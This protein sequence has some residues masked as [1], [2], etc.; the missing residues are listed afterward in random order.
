MKSLSVALATYNGEP[1]LQEELATI[2]AQTVLPTE[3][4]VADDGSTD[5]TLAIVRFFAKRAAFPVKA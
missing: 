1:Y 2:A 3:L 4:V 5:S